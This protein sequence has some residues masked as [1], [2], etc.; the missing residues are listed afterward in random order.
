MQSLQ[1]TGRVGPCKPTVTNTLAS[2]SRSCSPRH[3]RACRPA[4][5]QRLPQNLPVKLRYQRRRQQLGAPCCAANFEN[6][7]VR[8]PS[9]PSKRP[10]W[11]AAI[12][13]AG[14]AAAAATVV[15]TGNWPALKERAAESA[16]G[17]S[18]FL[19]AF[20]LI[21]ASEIGDRTFF[22]AGLLAAK[23]G[24]WVAFTG[25]CLALGLMTFISV[26]IGY[27]F[28]CV[29][30]AVKS[31]API[32]EYVGIALMLFFGARLLRDAWQMPAE[33]DGH[34]EGEMA[35][36]QSSL[37]DFEAK[38]K[39][40]SQ[41][42]WQRLLE[43]GSLIFVAEWG[44]R[45]MFATIALGASQNPFGVAVGAFLGHAVATVLA[46]LGGALAANYISEKTISYIGGA[47]FII[48]AAATAWQ[49]GLGF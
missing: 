38:G 18:G 4:A 11:I 36:A 22:I 33:E 5:P 1:S 3:C 31:S 19:A 37:K 6:T 17:R 27:A 34:G 30:D 2:Q 21:L 46:V 48:F 15:A 13:A 35:S 8:P 24:K 14:L 9:E 28:K 43:V 29:P 49:L 23:V 25:T 39:M 42:L 20:A 10:I 47:L 41:S 26:G 12:A 32:G 16:L 7:G 44:D 45:S 40:Q